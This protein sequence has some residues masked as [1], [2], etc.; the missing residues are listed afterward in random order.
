MVGSNW[1]GDRRCQHRWR[2]LAR[3]ERH[4]PRPARADHLVSRAPAV[5]AMLR[6]TTPTRRPERRDVAR[7]ACAG[8]GLEWSHRVGLHELVRRLGGSHVCAVY[9]GGRQVRAHGDADDRADHGDGEDRRQSHKLDNLL[10]VSTGPDGILV[11]A[12][13]SARAA[14]GSRAGSRRCRKRPTSTSARSKRRRPSRR[15]SI[16]RRPSAFRIRT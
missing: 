12:Q 13:P 8:C 11:E 7:R 15:P 14:A 1:L 4:A 3:R 5:A 10:A 6:G 16:S 2:R 9:R